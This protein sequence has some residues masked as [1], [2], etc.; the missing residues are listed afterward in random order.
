MKSRK[1][2]NIIYW[3]ATCWLALGM[4]SAAIVQIMKMQSEID[5]V[6]HLGYPI[7]FL[8]I[9]GVSKILGVIAVLLPRFPIVKE[10]AYAGFFFTMV[11]AIISHLSVGDGIV[12]IVPAALLLV[13]TLVSRYF[14]PMSRKALG[15]NA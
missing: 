9:L 15:D 1:V 12:E 7:Y 11:G 14:R 3:I 2:H 5:L 13:L 6:T 8:M 4:L 10:W